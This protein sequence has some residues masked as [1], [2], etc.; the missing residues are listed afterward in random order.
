M[1]GLDPLPSGTRTV[2]LAF[3]PLSPSRHGTLNVS[4][5][6]DQTA[7]PLASTFGPLAYPF[8]RRPDPTVAAPFKPTPSLPNTLRT[9]IPLTFTRLNRAPHS[10]TSFTLPF[11]LFLAAPP[12]SHRLRIQSR[13]SLS[14]I[15]SSSG[16][17]R[18]LPVAHCIGCIPPPYPFHED[19]R[20]LPSDS[21]VRR[22][23]QLQD[24]RRRLGAIGAI[25]GFGSTFLHSV[26]FETLICLVLKMLSFQ[27]VGFLLVLILQGRVGIGW[28]WRIHEL[29]AVVYRI[30]SRTRLVPHTPMHSHTSAMALLEAIVEGRSVHL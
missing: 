8:H 29:R 15:Q 28:L 12:P 21:D 1:I 20:N 27:T 5:A 25:R 16:A 10:T 9:R 26:G 30:A 6:S 2:I 4:Y 22:R 17:V 7:S 3:K 14:P 13:T 24:S 23:S 11:L 18:P 19:F